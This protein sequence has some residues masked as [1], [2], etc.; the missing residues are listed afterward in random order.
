MHKRDAH[1]FNEPSSFIPFIFRHPH[2]VLYEKFEKNAHS[3]RLL[4]P[5][6][7]ITLFMLLVLCF[8]WFRPHPDC[9]SFAPRRYH[10]C[11]W[12]KNYPFELKL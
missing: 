8:L 3:S 10:K 1:N 7:F 9:Y 2:A 5:L 6:L 11:V 4:F 12:R